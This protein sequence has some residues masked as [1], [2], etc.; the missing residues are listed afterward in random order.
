MGLFLNGFGKPS[1]QMNQLISQSK[2]N[3]VF[4]NSTI[5]QCRMMPMF[6]IFVY[7]YNTCYIVMVP[8]NKQAEIITVEGFFY[9][10]CPVINSI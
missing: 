6:L 4:L 5:L 10:R 3:N 1:V 8:E 9:S 7:V 2:Q